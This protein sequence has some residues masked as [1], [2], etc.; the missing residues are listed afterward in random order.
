MTAS[1]FATTFRFRCPACGEG[2]L[3]R[4]TF[5]LRETCEVCG[6]RY[7]RWAGTWLGPPVLAYGIAAV[8]AAGAGYGLY[9]AGYFFEGVEWVL[10]AI[11]GGAALASYR[12]VK[13]WWIWLL[14]VTGWV[15]PDRKPPTAS[16]PP[17]PRR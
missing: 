11:A 5:Q 9:V 4:T 16:P 2:G 6:V 3:Y 14:Y 15:F 12:S 17:T 13:A 10:S 7:E 1:M 8:V